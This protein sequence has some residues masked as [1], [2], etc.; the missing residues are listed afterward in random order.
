MGDLTGHALKS[1][2]RS[3]ARP[4]LADSVVVEAGFSSFWTECGDIRPAGAATDRIAVTRQSQRVGTPLE[5]PFSNF[6]HHGWPAASGT[7]QQN[8]NYRGSIAYVTGSV[9]RLDPR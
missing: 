4:Q 2:M 5:T 6:V 1:E 9:F 7:I 8:A 3:R